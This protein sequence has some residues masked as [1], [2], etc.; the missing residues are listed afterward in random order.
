ME[1][2]RWACLRSSGLT[3]ADLA[4]AR[5]RRAQSWILSGSAGQEIRDALKAGQLHLVPVFHLILI[6][7]LL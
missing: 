2:A 7:Q 6:L 1:R 3:S 5:L 4:T